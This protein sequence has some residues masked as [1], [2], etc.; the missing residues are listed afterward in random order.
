MSN[1][2]PDSC[3]LYPLSLNQQNI[4]DV[5]RACPDTSI[6]N[7]CA[8]LRIHGRLDFSALQRSINL[9]LAADD[10]LRT[11]IT[12]VDKTPMQ[13]QAPFQPEPIP[14][15][16]FSQTSQESI[17][18]WES[19]FTREIMPLFDA[20]LYRFILLRNSENSGGL[21][22]KMHHL[23]SDGWTQ[24]LLSNRIGQVYLDIL[25]G[26][27]PALPEIPVYKAHVEGEERYLSSPGYG[28]DEE[29][30]QKI[31]DK[32]GEPSVLKSV[33]GAAVSPVGRRL[34]FHLPEDLNNDIYAFCMG[35]RVAPFSAFYMALAIYFKRI[36]GADR[37]TIG[38]P[39]FNRMNR[40]AK[41]TSGMF[42]STLPFFSEISGDW[43]LNEFNDHL[44]EGWL[45]MLR[46]Q[47][48]PFSHIQAQAVERQESDRLFHIAFSYQNTQLIES[49]EA[50]VTF[51]GRWHYSGYQMQQLCIHLSNLEDN[52]RYAVD[53]D[54]LIQLFSVQE[55]EILHA[56]LVNILREALASPDRP[57][58]QL[59]VLGPEERERVLYTF[60]RSSKPIFEASLYG[61]FQ[62]FVTRSSSRAARPCNG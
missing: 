21:V 40:I 41:Q 47:R 44:N 51:A 60:N 31:L 26:K 33:R 55:I 52:R 36:G 14:I 53:Y 5:E 10:S 43:T 59:A 62:R 54:Y 6:N 56:C 23:I 18:N 9:V 32:A 34:T 24:V 35:H 7:I 20:P 8:T 28:R 19:S 57:I 46:H 49:K 4:W 1:F 30:W 45:N 22:F 50:T 61:R 27:E 37:F 38:V 11:R 58:R 13:Y 3:D 15:Y 25:A 29:Y 39:I 16:D 48:F 2:A 42:V 12:L 17:E